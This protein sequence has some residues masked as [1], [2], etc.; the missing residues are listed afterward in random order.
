MRIPPRSE[1]EITACLNEPLGQG[2]WLL[3]QAP[4]KD[5]SAIVAQVLVG[6][7]TNQVPVRQLNPR[8]EE[9]TTIYA[10]TQTATIEGVK[11][12]QS[13]IATINDPME[14]AKKQEMLQELVENL[15]PELTRGERDKFLKLLQN[16]ADIFA[17]SSTDLGHTNRLRHRIDTG[18]TTPIRQPMRCV[19][20]HRK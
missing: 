15:E 2:A 6:T 16:Y 9:V 19:P 20:S 10:G 13:P 3:E 18:N 5:I 4:N 1:M 7:E 17:T 8:A 14:R 12:L 11:V